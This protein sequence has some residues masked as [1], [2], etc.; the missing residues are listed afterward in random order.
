MEVVGKK[1]TKM[2]KFNI[3]RTD[4]IAATIF[5]HSLLNNSNKPI[6]DSIVFRCL[7]VANA[8]AIDMKLVT[9]LGEVAVK[10]RSNSHVQSFLI[11]QMVFYAISRLH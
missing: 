11:K 5:R 10:T 3:Q 1:L 2:L 6:S 7:N 9:C 4:L 8:N